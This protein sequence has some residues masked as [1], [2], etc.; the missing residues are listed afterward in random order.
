MKAI[1]IDAEHGA[2]TELALPES[3]AAR[4]P[5]MQRV[6]GGYIEAAVDIPITPTHAETLYVDEEGLLKGYAYGFAWAGA[7]VPY[8]AGN[9]LVSAYDPTTGETRATRMTADEV[10]ARVPSYGAAEDLVRVCTCDIWN[11]LR[12]VM[13]DVW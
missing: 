10:R 12:R 6:V 9:G 8:Y 2:I 13:L 1:W 3:D 4:L 11:P 7:P 5:A